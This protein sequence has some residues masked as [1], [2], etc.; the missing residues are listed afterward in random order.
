MN[1]LTHRESFPFLGGSWLPHISVLTRTESLLRAFYWPT[2]T[3]L[4]P[5]RS[6]EALIGCRPS[7]RPWL[8]SPPSAPG[9][10][11]TVGSG[12]SLTRCLCGS[13]LPLAWP[14]S[15]CSGDADS[16]VPPPLLYVP[17]RDRPSPHASSENAVLSASVGPS[18][19]GQ[20]WRRWW[21]AVPQS[22]H[23]S[24]GQ[25]DRGPG[26]GSG[27]PALEARHPD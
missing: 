3:G 17:Q 4:S 11:H 9:S 2:F 20:P 26:E 21:A 24:L 23:T 18:L 12:P 5:G 13:H 8:L 16:R 25:T 22:T 7:P 27:H 1:C 6:A 10:L 14:P 19:P 15:R